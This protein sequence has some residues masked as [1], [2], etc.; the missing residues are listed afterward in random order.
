M[1]A[2]DAI[3]RR[4]GDGEWVVVTPDGGF[5][6]IEIPK[7]IGPATLM[8]RSVT[9]ALKIRTGDRIT[10]ALSRDEVWAVEAYALNQVVVRHLDGEMSADEMLEIVSGL[11]YG[12]QVSQL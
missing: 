11:G 12:W 3:Q 5:L 10:S 4:L 7:N 1:L 6:D 8:V 9:D 2:I